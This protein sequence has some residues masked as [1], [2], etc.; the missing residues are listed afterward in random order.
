M[1][2]QFMNTILKCTLRTAVFLPVSDCI[3]V[4]ACVM[5]RWLP[6]CAALYMCVMCRWLP[7]CAA[8]YMCVMCRWLPA[9]AALYMCVMCRWLPACAALYMCVMCR[10]LPACAALYMCVMC[11]WLP[12]CA[13]YACVMCRWLPAC[14]ALFIE[15]KDLW[16]HLVPDND[17][18]ST[19]LVQQYF[20]CVAM[21]MSLQLRSTV[22]N[23][24]AD[25]LDFLRIHK[26]GSLHPL[27][28][29]PLVLAFSEPKCAWVDPILFL[30]S[31]SHHSP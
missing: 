14:A 10:W 11:R 13:I 24:L 18:E 25:F 12:A 28:L 7:A 31:I 1:V 15:R 17:T 22:V 26:V 19:L 9:C 20:A 21:L 4:Y 30:E 6:A 3:S 16:Q 27:H 5:C 23:S 29:S 2:F 8:L